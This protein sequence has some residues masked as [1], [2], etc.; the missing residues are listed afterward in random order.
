MFRALEGDVEVDPAHPLITGGS[1]TIE[2]RLH[3]KLQ[4]PGQS[5]V[6]QIFEDTG[7]VV[8]SHQP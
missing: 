4:A 1:L 6:E 3:A 7:T 8:F 5:P 2:S